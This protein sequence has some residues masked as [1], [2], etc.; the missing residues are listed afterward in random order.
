[1]HKK[2]SYLVKTAK[3]FLARMNIF[4]QYH[5]TKS[6]K[7]ALIYKHSSLFVGE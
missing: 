1:M 7:L 2:I 6:S 3:P 4:T 5:N